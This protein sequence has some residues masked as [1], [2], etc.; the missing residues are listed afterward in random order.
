MM[1]PICGLCSKRFNPSEEGGTVRFANYEAL[2]D[3]VVGHPTGLVWFCGEHIEEAKSRSYM[4]S[5]EAID[6]M[7]VDYSSR[8]C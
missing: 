4:S 6:E 8:G 1:P 3:G 2:P 5:K 7:W